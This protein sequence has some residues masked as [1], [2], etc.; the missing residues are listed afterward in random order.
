MNAVRVVTEIGRKTGKKQTETIARI[1]DDPGQSIII[2]NDLNVRL[3][4]FQSFG[5]VNLGQDVLPVEADSVRMQYV[6]LGGMW[7][8]MTTNRHCR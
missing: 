6:S 1:F 4:P 5:C 8:F 2:L 3:E 7:A